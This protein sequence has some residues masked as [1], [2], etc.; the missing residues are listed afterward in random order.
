MTKRSGEYK[1]Y[2]DPEVMEWASGFFRQQHLCSDHSPQGEPVQDNDLDRPIRLLW[3][4]DIQEQFDGRTMERLQ[5]S[6]S[7]SSDLPPGYFPPGWHDRY[8]IVV[9]DKPKPVSLVEF[10]RSHGVGTHA[11]LATALIETGYATEYPRSE[12]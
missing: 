2:C 6:G 4:R 9:R 12:S 7:W 5:D 8:W 1:P 3:G 10:L 11:E